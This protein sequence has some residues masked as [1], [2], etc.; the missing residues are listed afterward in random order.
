MKNIYKRAYLEIDLDNLSHNYNYIKKVVGD[1]VNVMSVVKA[2]GYGHGDINVVK[3]LYSIGCKFFGVSNINE[4]LNISEIAKDAYVLNLG[5]IEVEHIGCS[6]DK[7]IVQTIV[8]LEHGLDLNRELEKLNKKA[9]CHI[10]L[11]T[12][13]SRIGVDCFEKNAVENIVKIL[14]LNNLIVE[15][16]FTHFPVADELSDE[17]VEFTNNQIKTFKNIVNTLEKKGY[18]FLYKHCANSAGTLMFKTSYFN[19]VRPGTILYG[20]LPSDDLAPYCTNFKEILGLKAQVSLVKTVDKGRSVNYGR[21]FITK[22]KTKLATITIGYADG[23]RRLSFP[24][25]YVVFN[26]KKANLAGRVCMDQIV[27]DV[28]HIDNIKHGDIVTMIGYDSISLSVNDF[29]KIIKTIPIEFSTS[30]GKRLPRVY[31]KNKNIT[32]I[33][34]Y[35]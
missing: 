22:N 27:I 20:L 13:M 21:K 35:S 24:D 9:R 18:S 16:I 26:G 12:G 4:A 6:V 2:N 8:N 7:N 34:Y 14:S 28:S 15:G 31:L 1:S 33:I 29:A 3:H 23:Y 19:M 5:Y 25:A 10:K 32:D 30:L 11:D 17:S